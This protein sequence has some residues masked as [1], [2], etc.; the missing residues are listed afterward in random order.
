MDPAPRVPAAA[1]MPPKGFA[2]IRQLLQQI[3]DFDRQLHERAGGGA[4][5]KT[6]ILPEITEHFHEMRFATTEEAADPDSLLFLAPQAIKVG[7]ENPLQSAGVFTVADKGFQLESERLDLALVMP[8]SETFETP[9]FSSSMV[10]GS[11]K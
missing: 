11:R 1:R 2:S 8:I 3:G 5:S 6:V 7:P 9:L 10:E 4:V